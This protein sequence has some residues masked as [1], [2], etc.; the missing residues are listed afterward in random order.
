M[1]ILKAISVIL[2]FGILFLVVGFVMKE[3]L[4]IEDVF[5]YGIV[6]SFLGY[7]LGMLHI[8]L[9]DYI[10]LKKKYE[11]EHGTYTK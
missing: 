2:P 1:K 10:P 4:Y 3:V 7:I 8:Y 5:I 9:E 11:K 6:Y